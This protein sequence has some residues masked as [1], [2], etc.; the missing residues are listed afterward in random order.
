MKLVTPTPEERLLCAIW[1]ICPDC[2]GALTE[3]HRRAK[4]PEYNQEPF[5]ANEHTHES[6][7]P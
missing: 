2:P 7:N 1:N 4:L 5:P 6:E 3:L